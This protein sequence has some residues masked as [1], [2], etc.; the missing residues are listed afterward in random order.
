MERKKIIY[1]WFN[2]EDSQNISELVGIF[3]LLGYESESELISGNTK[4]PDSEKA[5]VLKEE[6][7]ILF[8]RK[9]YEEGILVLL[10]SSIF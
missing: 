8:Q 2:T 4:F 6:G 7:N 1:D 5:R 3:G 10:L 9:D